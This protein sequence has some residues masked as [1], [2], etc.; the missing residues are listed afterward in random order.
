[1][2]IRFSCP[3]CAQLVGGADDAA[4][5]Q[6]RCGNCQSTVRAPNTP[7][8]PPRGGSSGLPAVP[9]LRVTGRGR[10]GVLVWLPLALS[11]LAF[12]AAA[13]A[14]GVICFR[15]PLGSG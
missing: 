10:G 15:D 6:V 13:I 8:P 9:D 12:V 1:M 4:G 7:S 2:A 5:M 3:E 11:S 14:L